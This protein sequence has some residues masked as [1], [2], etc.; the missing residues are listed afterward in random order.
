MNGLA[1]DTLLVLDAMGVLY[2]IGDDVTHLLIPFIA[3]SG[4]L[5]DAAR[6]HALYREASLGRLTAD[7][8]WVNVGLD[9]THE[10]LH[11]E[12]HE[13]A[14][15]VWPLLKVAQER[16]AGIACLS[17]DVGRWSQKLR[18]R[19]GLTAAI[20]TWVISGDVGAR[21]PDPAIYQI[22]LD[23]LQVEP[24]RVLFADD[25]P[26]NLDAARALGLRT[27]WVMPGQGDPAVKH[28]HIQRLAE[29]VPLLGTL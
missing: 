28:P 8:F 20:S 9:P 24:K 10:N 1:R 14:P 16:R 3:Q 18:E 4:G 25:N 21:K 15:D 19:F 17:N 7:D 6:I 5:R 22:L 12:Q 23:R 27:V 13:L 11:L 2:R 29:L 26:Q